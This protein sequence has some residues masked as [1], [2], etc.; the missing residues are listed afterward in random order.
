MWPREAKSLSTPAL[1][2]TRWVPAA[3]QACA[4][5]THSFS[6]LYQTIWPPFS[7]WTLRPQMCSIFDMLACFTVCA[8][9]CARACVC[10]HVHM[11]AHVFG[12][13]VG[14]KVNLRCRTFE[15]IDP[16]W[17]FWFLDSLAL[18]SNT[19]LGSLDRQLP[20]ICLSLLSTGIT[21]THH[22]AWLV[23]FCLF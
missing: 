18:S 11:S 20:P 12:V 22:H 4:F 9:A 6:F 16:G 13:H 21:S 1:C 2:G 10:A 15:T 7:L 5:S 14:A 23:C 8:R 17:L 3:A 19:R